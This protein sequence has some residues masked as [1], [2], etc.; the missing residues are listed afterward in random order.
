MIDGTEILAI[1]GFTVDVT[2]PNRK[3]TVKGIFDDE[4]STVNI[5]IGIG[6]TSPQITLATTVADILQEND[7]LWIAGREYLCTEPFEPDDDL[8]TIPLV[9]VN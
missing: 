3:A 8:T 2:L 4:S 9:K 5:G 1:D 6:T 7:S